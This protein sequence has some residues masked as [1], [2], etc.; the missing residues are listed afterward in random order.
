LAL[1][2]RSFFGNRDSPSPRRMLD[3]SDLTKLHRTPQYFHVE[4]TPRL[5]R[6][7]PDR[8]QDHLRHLPAF[9]IVRQN[10]TKAIARKSMQLMQPD[11][12]RG[13]SG[14]RL[15]PLPFLPRQARHLLTPYPLPFGSAVA[16]LGIARPVPLPPKRGAGGRTSP[17]FVSLPFRTSRRFMGP[18]VVALPHKVACYFSAGE[19][20]WHRVLQAF[21]LHW[22]LVHPLVAHSRRRRASVYSRPRRRLISFGHGFELGERAVDSRSPCANCLADFEGRNP[23]LRGEVIDGRRL[24]W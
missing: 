17:S 14:D 16:D 11:D 2:E 23:L 1:A 24:I 5:C 20:D 4:I 6:H 7:G 22:A 19:S 15:L 8:G 3:S 12:A 18:C 10:I 9:V 21:V 13:V